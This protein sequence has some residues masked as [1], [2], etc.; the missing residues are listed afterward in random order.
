MHG[1]IDYLIVTLIISNITAACSKDHDPIFI[2]D[3]EYVQAFAFLEPDQLI[4]VH[5]G[6]IAIQ[7]ILQEQIFRR[8]PR[9]I[10]DMIHFI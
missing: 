9:R 10:D 7:H 1:G 3:R 2:G 6:D 4:G 8:E 5:L